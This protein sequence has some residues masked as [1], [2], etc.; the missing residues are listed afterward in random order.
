M[1]KFYF[2]NVFMCTSSLLQFMILL[3]LEQKEKLII[4]DLIELFQNK[5]DIQIILNEVKFL[6][7]HPSFNPKKE[8]NR[9]IIIINTGNDKN[10]SNNNDNNDLIN[11]KLELQISLNKTFS[12][13]TS[14]I[15]SIPMFIKTVN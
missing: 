1:S 10:E 8:K 3:F 12:I 4:K 6:L 7:Y 15:I 9:G 13:N 5:V 2:S 14:K 11:L